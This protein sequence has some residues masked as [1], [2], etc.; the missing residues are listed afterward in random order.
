MRIKQLQL[1]KYGKFD[2]ETIDFPKAECD[3]HV[4]SG[5]NEA[6]KST[7]RTAISE[8]LFGMPLRSNL[9]FRHPLPE[10]CLGGTL[11]AEGSE[12]VFRRVR[13]RTPLRTPEGDPLPDDHLSHLLGTVDKGQFEKMYCLDHEQLVEGGHTILDGSKEVGRVLFQS[14]AGVTS[15]GPVRA[16]LEQRAGAL[17][18]R[19]GGSQYAL[20][21]TALQTATDELKSA[22]VRTK[23]WQAAKAE[24]DT[25]MDEIAVEDGERLKL[26][27]L[28]AKLERV[29]RLSGPLQ[30]LRAKSA[31]LAQLGPTLELPATAMADLNEGSAELAATELL[32]SERE[33]A[34]TALKKARA[35]ISYDPQLIALKDD[36]EALDAM[37]STSANH[38]RDL[39]LR[40]AEVDRHV[41]AAQAAAAQIGWP[42]DEAAMRARQPTPLALKTVT[43]LMSDRGALREAER[44]AAATAQ[45]KQQEMDG[46]RADLDAITDTDIPE[47]LRIA[48][49]DALTFRDS[50]ARQRTQQA[51]VD[52]AAGDLE[53][54]LAGLAPWVMGIHALRAMS[55][56]SAAR[57]QKLLLQRQVA[58]SAVDGARDALQTARA[59][60]ARRKL[61]LGQFE[62]ANKV[63][64]PSEV[65][66]ARARRDA[67]WGSVKDRS[68]PLAEGA[69]LLDSAIRLADELVDAQLGTATN[70]ASLEALRQGL[71][72]A[73]ADE[74]AAQDML[75][76]AAERLASFDG[77]WQ[78]MLLSAGL[79]G[80][81]LEDAPDWLAKRDAALSHH[82]TLAKSQA[83]RDEEI[84]AVARS[85][86]AIAGALSSVGLAVTEQDQ[87]ATLAARAGS[88]IGAAEAARARR[89]ELLQQ[90]QKAERALQ[91]AQAD[92]E[93]KAKDHQ[94]WQTQW[95]VALDAAGLSAVAAS[96]AEA[97]G[98]VELA[99]VVAA[100]LKA[101][102]DLRRNRID[103]MRADLVQLDASARHMASQVSPALLELADSSAISHQLT[104]SLRDALAAEQR[105]RDADT[106][107]DAADGQRQEAALRADEARARLK[108]L[109]DL[110]GAASIADAIPVVT[111]ADDGRTL[112]SEIAAASDALLQDGDGLSIEGIEAEVAEYAPAEV[113]GLHE[114]VKADAQALAERMTGLI[115]RRVAAES[116]FTAI[117]GQANAAIAEARRQEALAAMGEAAEEYLEVATAAKLLKWAVDCYRDRKQGPM[118]QRAGAIF[119]TL[120][121]GAFRKLVVDYE[122]DVPTLSAQR[123]SGQTVE[124]AG[125]SEGTRDQL[126]MALRIAAIELQLESTK[127]LPFVADDLFINFDDERAQAGLEVLRDLSGRTQVIFLTHHKHL[128]PLVRQVFGA[129]VNLVEL[130]R[131]LAAASGEPETPLSARSS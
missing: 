10:L 23:A 116:A 11:E 90:L 19:R 26:E 59:A 131:D 53:R 21:A 44:H 119:A 68:L 127:P 83:V 109:L 113:I 42:T 105:A 106:N 5:P 28:R 115:Q 86:A 57:V 46:L 91:S 82:E 103:T 37:R 66:A 36:I 121:L 75:A 122:K 81:P 84:Q 22:Q 6:G 45:E 89:K 92:A 76:Q 93:S 96:F 4:V 85:R 17:W 52:A 74:L 41:L 24:L 104:R 126:F 70:A 79:D 65:H 87:L 98:A 31:E 112:R 64:T 51:A 3:F 128:I 50:P 78:A 99:N 69:P 14:A 49:E 114:K 125:L 129:G 77:D 97:E 33:K 107:I 72:T 123:G 88:F 95:R 35:A 16:A 108:P 54:A 100:S 73:Q 56:P 12:T 55:A 27:A 20:A 71:E 32:L 9:A 60:L 48:H 13:G 62:K 8:L 63:V 39:P 2:G 67:T 117:A 30:T 130:E 110:A 43:R 58:Q 29:R 40:Q 18:A 15:L 120:T 80:M 47:T 1:L 34:L 101:A 38:A 124:V 25:V 7:L 102:D 111:R 94:Q 118:L 61:Q